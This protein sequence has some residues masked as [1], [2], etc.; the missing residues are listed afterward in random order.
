MKLLFN[1]ICVTF[2]ISV[3]AIAIRVLLQ[4]DVHGVVSISSKRGFTLH[5]GKTKKVLEQKKPTAEIKLSLKTDKMYI[6]GQPSQMKALILKPVSK[7]FS[8]DHTD[9]DGYLLVIQDKGRWHIV[10]ILDSEDYVF[11]VL[12]TEGWPGWPLEV[13]KVFAIAVR[14]YVMHHYFESKRLKNSYHIRN[15][16]YHQTY[17]GVHSCPLI[18]EAVTQTSGIILT[19]DNKPILA[20]FDACCGGVVPAQ[21]EGVVDF[22]KAP[23]LARP[24]PCTFCKSFKIFSWR[25]EYTL[26]E[27]RDLL[28][29]GHSAILY[30]IHDV[31]VHQKDKAGLVKAVVTKTKNKQ[32]VS[33]VSSLFSK[34]LKNIK[35]LFYSIE[36][37]DDRI[38]VK[39]K[40]YGHHLGLCQWGAREMV[41]QG[42]DSHEI[43]DFYYPGVEF[44][45]ME[46]E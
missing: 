37:H 46:K 12:K 14:T 3:E 9:Y 40:G 30:D 24:Y 28:Q 7:H 18:K 16:N 21:I 6:N 13:Y 1:I 2:F 33:F 22:I 5:D 29:E 39:G 31:K 32:T 44:H 4:E 43:L 42:W 17:Q 35:S 38:I 19:H 45:R 8:L 41:R 26:D 34:L 15:T 10:N 11:S 23:Y 27:L 36:K 20:M 25:N